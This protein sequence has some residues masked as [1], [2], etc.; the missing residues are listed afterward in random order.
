MP[1]IVNKG[2]RKIAQKAANV[3][4]KRIE[5]KANQIVNKLKQ[6][7]NKQIK[8]AQ[9]KGSAAVRNTGKK[10]DRKSTRLNSSH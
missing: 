7:A 10:L 4:G 6:D 1:A 3:A 9:K 2:D 5:A 8:V